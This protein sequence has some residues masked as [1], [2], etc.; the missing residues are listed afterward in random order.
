[1]ANIQTQHFKLAG[2]TGSGTSYF[3]ANGEA[4]SSVS[5]VRVQR[6]WPVAGV[7]RKMRV[8]LTAA[9]TGGTTITFTFRL[10]EASSAMTLTFNPGD[11]DLTYTASSISVSAGDRVNFQTVNTGSGGGTGITLSYEFEP[12]TGSKSVYGSNFING[13]GTTPLYIGPTCGFITQGPTLA[14]VVCVIP[15]PG[16][17]TDAAVCLDG[18]PGGS[19]TWTLWLSTNNGSS[20][21]KQDGSGGTPDTSV[22]LTAARTGTTSFSLAVSAGDLVYATYERLSGSGINLYG[23][24]SIAFDPTTAGQFI[25]PGVS[26]STLFTGGTGYT[27][28]AEG[29]TPPQSSITNASIITGITSVTLGKLYVY[30]SVAPGSTKSYQFDYTIDESTS[31]AGGSPTVTVTGTAVTGNDTSS[32]LALTDDHLLTLRQVPTNSPAASL[33]SWAAMGTTSGGGG[34]GATFPS[35]MIAA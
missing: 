26:Q 2:G 18:A 5:E 10:N 33:L 31:P 11:T 27:P 1:M 15:C 20:F 4:D 24:Y 25:I 34:G 32:T 3:S 13:S 22:N 6:Y 16:T 8:R 23:G 35:L 30:L 14:A 28:G 19:H 17:I 7:V 9:V 29:A 12:T 21:T